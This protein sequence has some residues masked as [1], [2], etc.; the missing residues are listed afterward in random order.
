MSSTYIRPKSLIVKLLAIYLPLVTLS[1]I[2]LFSVLEMRF[3]FDQR[4]ELVSE[5]KQLTTVQS[6]AFASAV[7]EIDN[8]QINSLLSDIKKLPMISDA[9]VYD[10]SGELLGKIGDVTVVPED[11][12]FRV[13]M[14]LVFTTSKVNEAVGKLVITVHANLIREELFDRIRTDILI[15]FVMA[16]SLAGVTFFAQRVV[17]GRPI[18]RLRDSI[19]KMRDENI[20]EQ[21]DWS[22]SDELGQVVQAYNEMQLAQETAESELKNHQDHLEELIAERTKE[23]EQAKDLAEGANEELG[24]RVNELADAR[25]ATLNIMADV[26]EARQKAEGLRDQAEEATRAKS[27]FLAA[28]SHEIRTPMNGV[29]G[30]IDLLRETEMTPDQTQM[31]TTVRDSAFS[32]LQIIND[33]LD[34]SKIEAGKMTLEEIPMSVRDVIQG[35]V[36]TMTPNASKKELMIIP[37]I[38]PKIPDSVAGDQVRLRQILFNLGGNAIKFTENTETERGKIVIRADYLGTDDEDKVR[39]RYS[40]GDNGIGISEEAQKTLFEAFT[41]A[42][43]STTRRFGGTGLGLTICTRLAELMGGEIT[44]NSVLGEGSTFSAELLHRSAESPRTDAERNDLSNLSVLLITNMPD[45]QEFMSSY[46]SHWNAE[47]EVWDEID[48][49]KS[50]IVE[51]SINGDEYD[52]VVI[53][54]DWDADRQLKIR[55]QLVADENFQDAKFVFLKPYWRRG[56]RLEDPNTVS[57]DAMPLRR[58]SF[59]TAIAVA[60]GRASPETKTAEIHESSTTVKAMTVEEAERS[61]QLILIAE[62]NITNQDVIRRQLAQLGYA[63]EIANDGEEALSFWK[64]KKYAILLTDCHMPNM[65]GYELTGAIREAEDE[66]DARFPIVAITANALQGEADRC[67]AAGMDDYLSKPLEMAKLKQALKKWMPVS[68]LPIMETMAPIEQSS[69]TEEQSELQ[70]P[71]PPPP[72]AVNDSGNGGDPVDPSSLYDMFG[73]DPVAVTEILKDFVDPATSNVMEIVQGFTD[74][75]ASAVAA[76]AHKLKSSSRAVGANTLADLCLS[77]ETAGKSEDWNVIDQDAPK[78]EAAITEVVDY[79]NEL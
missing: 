31:M 28:M 45:Y 51:A 60:A 66:S 24:S 78:L 54:L 40:I 9:G 39:I 2:I 75:S 47:A 70:P 5:L 27:A 56:A 44:V 58:P 42:E 73:D 21:V 72:P 68:S 18:E 32:L 76:A 25:R 13:S 74:R 14:P 79:I 36:D 10:T 61:G 22:S 11:P 20:R 55:N 17:I 33:I 3:Y 71:P 29:V 12:A 59:L 30:M 46:L 49:L 53:G 67:L 64:N 69:H 23:L 19:Q 15:V 26:E 35:V 57:L 1:V 77:L 41:Q 43:S 37:Y 62:D 38:D 7:W 16:L 4:D 34:F 63:A 50:R 52:I 6:S 8:D 65:D 48:A